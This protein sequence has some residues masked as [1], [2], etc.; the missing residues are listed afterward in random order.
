MAVRVSSQVIL[1]P[2]G[3]EAKYIAKKKKKKIT[4][5]NIIGSSNKKKESRRKKGE[6]SRSDGEVAGVPI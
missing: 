6:V 5:L 2:P 1:G 3:L 4:S